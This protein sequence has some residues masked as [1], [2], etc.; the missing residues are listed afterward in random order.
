MKNFAK[1]M[2]LLIVLIMAFSVNAYATENNI[3]EP[4][5]SVQQETATPDV[6]EPEEE[7]TTQPGEET[8]Q[9]DVTDPSEPADPSE[10]TEPTE[11][12]K[13]EIVLPKAPTEIK[14]GSEGFGYR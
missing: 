2:C 5:T 6:T 8:T 1:I 10:P 3:D 11:P 9:P 7:T 13:T 14:A 12:E 4:T